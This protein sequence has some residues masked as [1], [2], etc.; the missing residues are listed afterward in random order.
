MKTLLLFLM[1]AGQAFAYTPGPIISNS[2]KQRV[3]LAQIASGNPPSIIRQSG[4][5]LAFLSR[6]APGSYTWTMTGFAAVPV[7]QMVVNNY[8]S[9]TG[10]A[11]TG[12]TSAT[13]VTTQTTNGGTQTDIDGTIICMG[14]RQ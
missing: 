12:V 4:A 10:F 7:C 1:T 2:P 8:S 13:R 11:N 3:E 14:L 6:G 9:G 5:W